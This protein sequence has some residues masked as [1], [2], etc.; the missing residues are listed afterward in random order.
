MSQEKLAFE[1]PRLADPSREPTIGKIFIVHILSVMISY[2][3]LIHHFFYSALTKV[4]IDQLM[5]HLFDK[6][7]PVS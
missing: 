1:C 5:G 4:E 2:S 7:S 6:D 3:N